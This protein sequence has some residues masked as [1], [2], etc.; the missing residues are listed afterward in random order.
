MA[1]FH[2]VL[3]RVR[4]L[5][6]VGFVQKPQ[7]AMARKVLS[8][9]QYRHGQFG[10][11]PVDTFGA[12]FFTEIGMAGNCVDTDGC[13]AECSCRHDG[14]ILDYDAGAGYKYRYR[15]GDTE[16]WLCWWWSNETD[17]YLC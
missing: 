4:S 6:H 15:I 8:A 2:P 14:G 9:R 10:N 11:H 5:R 16:D 17:D 1:R 3:R 13:D 12:V 7:I